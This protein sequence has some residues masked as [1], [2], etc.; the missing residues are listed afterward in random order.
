MKLMIKQIQDTLPKLYETEDIKTDNKI[1]QVRYLSIYSNW[2]WYL[3][4]YD[5]ISKVAF[6]YVMGNE[7]EWGYFSLEEFQQI[8]DEDLKI[9]RDEN[10]KPIKFEELK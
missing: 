4:E 2:E 1:L 7:N 5:D 8:N 6:G 10:F 9:V 3:V